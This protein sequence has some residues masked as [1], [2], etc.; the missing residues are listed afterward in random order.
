MT[1]KERVAGI[2][3]VRMA[4]AVG[5]IIFHFSCHTQGPIRPLYMV[6]GYAFGEI[7]TTCFIVLSGAMMYY[8]HERVSD[9][10]QFWIKRFKSIYPAFW[11]AYF[12]E[13]INNAVGA[14]T[15]FWSGARRWTVIVSVMGLDGYLMTGGYGT[16]YIIGE[17]FLGVIVLLYALYPALSWCAGKS[18]ALTGA[19]VYAAYGAWLLAGRPFWTGMTQNIAFFYTGM[20]LIRYRD[21]IFKG[22]IPVAVSVAVCIL[23]SV[24]SAPA[25]KLLYLVYT[26]GVLIIL[27]RIGALAERTAVTKW[28]SDFV[29]GISYE[30]FLVQH[31]TIL[32]LLRISDPT[33]A[34]G[35]V[36]TLMGIILVTVI[37]AWLLH[38]AAA[39][40]V[41]SCTPYIERLIARIQPGRA[42]KADKQ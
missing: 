11:I 41:K 29:G 18:F 27:Q 35:V 39:G 24:I 26:V 2:S 20:L 1:G 33:T 40:A 38:L 15:L 22:A 31:L 3:F 23:I 32:R 4:L 42:E 10:L 30:M 17:W 8:N 7:I 28:I 19:A 36:T 6:N 14:G 34:C 37:Y 21:R 25:Y 13:Y 5:I 16:F 9:V 12:I